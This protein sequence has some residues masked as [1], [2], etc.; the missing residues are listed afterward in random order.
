MEVFRITKTKFID[1]LGGTGARLHGGR[2]NSVGV[3]VL[4]TASLR[5]LAMLE[6]LAYTPFSLLYDCSLATLVIPDTA[7][8][9]LLQPADLPAYWDRHPAP[10]STAVFGDQ[11]L[12]ENKYLLIGVPS[13]ILPEEYNYLIN[14]LHSQINEITISHQRPLVF[15]SRFENVQT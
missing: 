7:A 14:P 3:S 11:F 6:A 2:W 4:Y 13:A 12:K 8:M 9:L 5:S 10:A 15:S 1:D